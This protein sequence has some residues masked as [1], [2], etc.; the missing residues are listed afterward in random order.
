MLADRI[1]RVKP[2][3]TLAVS[4][5]ASELRAAGE[6]II[7]LG[8][9]EPDFD[10]PQHIKAKAKRAIDE[11]K[12]KYT[13][14][15]GI[16]E[17]KQAVIKKYMQDNKLEYKADEVIVGNGGKQLIYNLFHAVL[18]PGDEVLI[19]TPYWV[20]YPDIAYLAEAEAK[21]IPSTIDTDYKISAEQLEQNI[22]TKSKILVLN[23]PSNPTGSMYEEQ[24]LL[25]LAEVLKKHDQILIASDDIYEKIILGTKKY[26][27]ILDVA[28]ELKQRTIMLNGVSKAYAM[29]GWRI[30]FAAGPAKIIQAMKKLQ[31][32]STSNPCSISQYAALAALEGDQDFIKDMNLEFAKRNRYV[33][34]EL[35]LILGVKAKYADGAFYAFADVKELISRLDAIENDVELCEYLL[36]VAKVAIVPG[37]VFGNPGYVRFSCATSM[38]NL[39]NAIKRIKAVLV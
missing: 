14:V 4:A 16:P 11:G 31:S 5:K 35:N 1:K 19:P 37:S 22:S 7:G 2:S 9:G 34:D 17:L 10:T 12:T 18:N 28:S 38:E 36:N 30:G 39:Q 26:V 23:S 25:A 3:A 33:V 6:D 32:Q 29:T 27:S 8:S 20:S 13:A 15:D 21:F 24:E